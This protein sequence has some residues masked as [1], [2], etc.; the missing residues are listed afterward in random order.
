MACWGLP[1]S[2]T[3][4]PVKIPHPSRVGG[5][6]ALPRGLLSGYIP[7]FI[8]RAPH[9]KTNRMSR[10]SSFF[11]GAVVGGVLVF[12]AVKFHVV[13][14]GEGFHL[15][16]RIDP[17]LRDVYVDIRHFGLTDWSNHRSLAAAIIRAKKEHLLQ[18]SATAGF[19]EG[20][21]NAVDNITGGA[22]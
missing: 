2:H 22:G 13:R 3:S 18:D 19:R 11:L 17:T 21:K 15:I 16:P 4:I 6:L 20:L 5:E 1:K 14:A 10:L 7:S 12:G 9:V 8:E